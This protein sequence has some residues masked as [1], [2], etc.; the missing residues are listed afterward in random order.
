M[1]I[2]VAARL[3]PVTR[4][5]R[6]PYQA[7]TVTVRRLR[8]PEWATAKDAALSILRNDAEL[9]NLLVKH[10][11]LPAGGVRGW[12][13]M[14]DEDPTAYAAFLTGVGMWLTAV[15]CGLVGI[16]AWTGIDTEDGK[17]APVERE[18]LEGL[19]LDEALSD[20]LMQV[21]TE[22]ARLFIAEG[23]PFGASPNGSSGPGM[24]A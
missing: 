11:L 1:S 19:L 15:E 18:V 13:R 16:T 6:P 21:M 4:Q 23:E 12:K 3:D 5:L 14:K 9:L 24:T 17:P 22:A 20:Q 7:V 2:R 10:D 8:S